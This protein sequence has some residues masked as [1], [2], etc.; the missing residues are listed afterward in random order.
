MSVLKRDG[1][2]NWYIQF[3]F[4]G[5][6]YIKSSRS[7]DKRTAERME[8]EW[9]VK[10]HSQRFLGQK[11]GI[12]FSTIMDRF[13]DTKSGTPN[14]PTLLVHSRI[15]HRLFPVTSSLHEITNEDIEK[16]M[17]TRLREGVSTQTIKH[18]F[19][20]I[21]GAWKYGKKLGY[22]VS[23]I[24]FPVLTLPKHR[25]RY[26]TIEEEQRL[27]AA[28]NPYR[29]GTGL[30]PFSERSEEMK[31][32]MQDAY[33]LVVLLL[34]TGARYSEI[35]NIEWTS[36]DLKEKTIRLWRPK[37]RNESVLYMTDRVFNILT[38]RYQNRRSSYVF[39]NSKGGPRGY[40]TQSIRKAFKKVGLS[41]CTVHTFRHTHATRLI[42]NGLSV[43]EVKEIL[44]HSD[45][46]T[47]MRYAHLEQRDVSSRA[48]DVINQLNQ[49]GSK[50]K[51]KVV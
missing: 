40:A 29:E 21:N 9:K 23:D 45:I 11:E 51:L 43:Y 33:D 46:K 26:L 7:T 13:I 10:L 48:R 44:G 8:R 27:L 1:S 2:K 30:K 31:R 47:T 19:N 37:V 25:L 16:L 20:L 18:S 12:Q 15:L 34:D 28:L 36:I 41:D 35:S 32:T 6:T 14:H 3:Q 39:E 49:N 5:K 42:Q 38:R 17:M 50:P 22:L 4:H 24:E